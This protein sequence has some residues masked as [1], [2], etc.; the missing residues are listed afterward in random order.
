MRFITMALIL[1]IERS[2]VTI[3]NYQ[4]LLSSSKEQAPEAAAIAS[5]L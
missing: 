2:V 3:T 5:L 1:R 4:A